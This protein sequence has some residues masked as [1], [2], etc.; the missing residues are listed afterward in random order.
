MRFASG[1]PR[2]IFKY[3]YRGF[4]VYV[5][6]Q[7]P[8]NEMYLVEDELV[9]GTDRVLTPYNMD[10]LIMAHTLIM[11]YR[12]YQNTDGNYYVPVS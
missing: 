8:L 12:L 11:P 4:Y 6:E 1:Y 10:R 7:C 2:R 3:I 5:D 9:A